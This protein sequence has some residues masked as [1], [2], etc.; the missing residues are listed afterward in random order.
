MYPLCRCAS[1]F[2]RPAFFRLRFARLC[3]R[4]FL[5]LWYRLLSL[6]LFLSGSVNFLAFYAL[7]PLPP[8]YVTKLLPTYGYDT[9]DNL[10]AKT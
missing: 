2:A 3:E 4:F 6:I 7:P 10:I 5:A 9:Y 1:L 8:C